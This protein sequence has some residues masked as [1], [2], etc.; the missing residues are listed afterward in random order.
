MGHQG[1]AEPV[2]CLEPTFEIM[3][4]RW[5]RHSAGAVLATLR[6]RSTVSVFMPVM[7]SHHDKVMG[8]LVNAIPDSLGMK[9]FDQTVQDFSGLLRPFAARMR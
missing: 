8:R 4:G 6:H 2:T 1:L 9:F 5:T 3:E 7:K